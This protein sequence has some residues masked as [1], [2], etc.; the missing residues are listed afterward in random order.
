[1]PVVRVVAQVAEPV[2]RPHAGKC[3]SNR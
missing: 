2:N 1:V 3:R